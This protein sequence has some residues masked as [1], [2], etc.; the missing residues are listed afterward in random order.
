VDLNTTLNELREERERIDRA[1][2][3]LLKGTKAEREQR[4]CELIRRRKNLQ[5]KVDQAPTVKG[6]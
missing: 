3:D 1:I 2:L 5:R 6:K 4:A